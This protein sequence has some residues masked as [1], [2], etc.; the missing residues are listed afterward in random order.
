MVTFWCIHHIS[1]THSYERKKK[2]ENLQ[3]WTL[4]DG[5]GLL[6]ETTLK[7]LIWIGLC[8]PKIN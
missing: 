8:C 2:E 4:L 3:T 1:F 6:G 5:I 7:H